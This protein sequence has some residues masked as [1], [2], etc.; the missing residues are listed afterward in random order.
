M[1][2]VAAA[3]MIEIGTSGEIDPWMEQE[4]L[5]VKRL[6]AA[7]YRGSAAGNS[8]SWSHASE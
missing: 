2:G 7:I 8:N 3:D 1:I 4:N 5:S 6:L